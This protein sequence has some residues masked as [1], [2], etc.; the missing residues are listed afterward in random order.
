MALTVEITLNGQKHTV[1]ELR[2]KEN[3]AW[4][5]GLEGVFEDVAGVMESGP[6]LELGDG[7]AVAQLVRTLSKRVIGS[8]DLMRD[9]VL[10]YAPGLK[11]E[12]E[13]AYDSELM[14]A[15]VAI[16]GLAYPFGSLMSRLKVLGAQLGQTSRNSRSPSGDSGETNSTS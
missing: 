7:K 8:V 9:M 12:I 15:F 11:A 2:T 13:E 4:R 5:K 16:L 1:T 6:E 10:K 3:S 14:D